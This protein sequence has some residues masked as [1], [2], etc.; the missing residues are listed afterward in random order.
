MSLL[1]RGEVN[2]GTIGSEKNECLARRRRTAYPGV[3]EPYV[4]F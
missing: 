3:V 4:P 2:P 1:L